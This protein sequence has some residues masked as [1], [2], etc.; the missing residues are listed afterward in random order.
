MGTIANLRSRRTQAQLH[1]LAGV[2]HEIRLDDQSHRRKYLREYNQAFRSYQQ[3]LHSADLD[4]AIQCADILLVGDYHALPNAQHFAAELLEK[5]VQPGDRPVVL[6]LETV[7][8]RDQRILDQWWRR[9]IDSDELRRRIRFDAEWGYDWEPVLKLLT[10]GRDHCEAIYGLDCMP[11]EDLRRIGARDRHAAH[12]IQEIRERHP[13]AVILVLFGESHLAPAH[14][15]R[16]LKKQVPDQRILTILQN[17]D[18]LY[19]QATSDK[20]GPITAVQV[21]FN[22]L[23]VFNAT[24]LE[25]YEHYRLQLSRWCCGREEQADAAPTIYN[26]ILSFARMLGIER[27]SPHNRTQP[28]FLMD[29]LP[30]VC[31]TTSDPQFRKLL[32]S[33]LN[34][35]AVDRQLRRLEERGSLYVQQLNLLIVREFKLSSAAE[36]AARFLYYACQGLGQDATARAQEDF[37]SEAMEH[38]LA[39]FGSRILC[40]GREELSEER[41]ALDPSG[42]EFAG[43][44]VGYQLY[45][46]Y[47]DGRISTRR[48]RQLFLTKLNEPGTARALFR[49][50]SGQR[51]SPL[52]RRLPKT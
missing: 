52:R 3:A 33:R 47:I 24:P 45:D 36:E 14:L 15:P 18:P 38:A 17:V 30:E 43:C 9:E 39:Y 29:L 8:A 49:E 12:K 23:C 46:S 7:F 32:G 50:L 13:Q 2:G 6:G 16:I 1:A 28:R 41:S 37:Y 10:S 26:L 34:E 27:Y 48:L 40:G 44:L 19:W 11:R 5:R 25:K 51:S 31:S 4:A 35:D 22:V 42:S 21:E 20:A